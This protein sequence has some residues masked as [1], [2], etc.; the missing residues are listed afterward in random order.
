MERKGLSPS[1]QLIREAAQELV[2]TRDH[3][4]AW[5]LL[6]TLFELPFFELLQ[7]PAPH[8]LLAPRAAAEG[9]EAA[10][11]RKRSLQSLPEHLQKELDEAEEV[12]QTNARLVEGYKA[13]AKAAAK[14]KALVIE[15]A[16]LLDDERSVAAKRQRLEEKRQQINIAIQV[17]LS[18]GVPPIRAPPSTLA[19]STA[20]Q[21]VISARRRVVE[22]HYKRAVP[23]GISPLLAAK[24]APKGPA[25]AATNESKSLSETIAKTITKLTS[26]SFLVPAKRKVARTATAE[27][28]ATLRRTRAERSRIPAPKPSYVTELWKEGR[29]PPKEPA[30]D[31]LVR[32]GDRKSVV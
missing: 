11:R 29:R 14:R 12:L 1:H 16:A 27:A 10:A 5:D 8:A 19:A 18:A 25:T 7:I 26:L 28:P 17:S 3:K 4:G 2:E 32:D 20:A 9:R 30:N 21:P 15:E 31:D 6:A 13:T 22:D 23:S 24:E